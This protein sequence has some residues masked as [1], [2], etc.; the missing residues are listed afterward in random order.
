MKWRKYDE[1]VNLFEYRK[2][3]RIFTDF[4]DCPVYY[5]IHWQQ[6]V[7]GMYA[8]YVFYFIYFFFLLNVNDIR[9][10]IYFV[11]KKEEISSFIFI[12]I[13]LA[14]WNHNSDM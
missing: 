2:I 4:F 3:S 13:T 7:T 12:G 1:K 8:K 6:M 9:H 14:M 10:L 5:F 11:I